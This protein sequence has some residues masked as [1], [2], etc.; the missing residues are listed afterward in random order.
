MKLDLH[1]TLGK[2]EGMKLRDGDPLEL[3][4]SL[5]IRRIVFWAEEEFWP[6]LEAEKPKLAE[7]AKETVLSQQVVEAWDL[8]FA[9]KFHERRTFEPLPVENPAQPYAHLLQINPLFCEFCGFLAKNKRG[10]GGHQAH[11]HGIKKPPYV[12]KTNRPY[13]KKRGEAPTQSTA[14]L[15]QSGRLQSDHVDAEANHEPAEHPS[16]ENTPD[17]PAL[18]S[19]DLD[20][21][22]PKLTKMD[23]RWQDAPYCC[24]PCELGF[25]LKENLESHQVERHGMRKI[26]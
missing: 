11:A 6:A 7:L 1:V 14:L 21:C 24:R 9:K 20:Q 16:H 26:A 4:L 25:F 13:G 10:R 19:H 17:S 22:K 18:I 15:T 2:Q 12:R 23:P 8:A 3:E 5:G